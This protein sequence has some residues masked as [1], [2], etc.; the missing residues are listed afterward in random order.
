MLTLAVNGSS[1]MFFNFEEWP[2][3]PPDF[4]FPVSFRSADQSGSSGV[5]TVCQVPS[6]HGSEPQ[7]CHS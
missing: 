6:V 1:N 5:K 7:Q 4:H 3:V 2:H